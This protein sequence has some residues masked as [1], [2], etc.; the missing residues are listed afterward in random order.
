[1][2]L[3]ALRFEVTLKSVRKR[4]VNKRFFNMFLTFGGARIGAV[5]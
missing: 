3:E 1:M 5:V 4:V 2:R